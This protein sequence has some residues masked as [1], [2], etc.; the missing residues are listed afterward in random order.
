MVDSDLEMFWDL[1]H[2]VCCSQA[3]YNCKKLT[4]YGPYLAVVYHARN[5]IND[6]AVAVKLE[7]ITTGQPSSV[8]R[9]YTI[10]KRLEGGLGIPRALWFGRESTY[11]AL[12]LG[13]LGPSLHDLFLTHDRKFSL[14]TVVNLGIQ[15]VSR[16]VLG[17][18]R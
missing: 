11:H 10:L 5:I 16:V 7:S 17:F 8:Q 1:V 15:L 14:H 13:L 3:D 2:T 9:E 4:R 6:D 12:V 18:C